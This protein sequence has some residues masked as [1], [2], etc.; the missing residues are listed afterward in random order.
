MRG[1][2]QPRS[3]GVDAGGDD[4]HPAAGAQQH[5]SHRVGGRSAGRGAAAE[6]LADIGAQRDAQQPGREHEGE[7]L[8]NA[9]E[10]EGD[11]PRPQD[12]LAETQESGGEGERVRQIA[13]HVA[14]AGRQDGRR[15]KSAP[16]TTPALVAAA[17]AMTP[18]S[19]RWLNRKKAVAKAPAAAP[20][21][22]T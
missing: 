16:S 17:S 14:R 9:A 15:K 4:E 5:A 19:V 18:S 13:H 11:E 20:M 3:G 6:I 21:V 2:E 12:L 7:G 8:R 22:L 1:G 10:G